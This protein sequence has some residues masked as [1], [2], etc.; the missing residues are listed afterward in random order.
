MEQ[1]LDWCLF[2]QIIQLRCDVENKEDYTKSCL[3]YLQFCQ[4]LFL[5]MPRSSSRYHFRPSDHFHLRREC[6]DPVAWHSQKKGRKKRRN[7]REWDV[8]FTRDH[9]PSHSTLLSSPSFTIFLRAADPPTVSPLSSSR[10]HLRPSCALFPSRIPP[11]MKGASSLSSMYRVPPS[12]TCI[13]S[14]SFPAFLPPAIPPPRNHPLPIFRRPRPSRAANFAAP[15]RPTL[16]KHPLLAS[17]L[18]PL[19]TPPPPRSSPPFRAPSSPSFSIAH[20]HTRTEAGRR[21]VLLH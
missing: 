16:T 7:A 6:R 2:G 1:K 11:R 4:Y 10:R 3:E 13:F 14:S 9:P 12:S 20:G 17:P 19:R 5:H 8:R 18:S 15:L 21:P